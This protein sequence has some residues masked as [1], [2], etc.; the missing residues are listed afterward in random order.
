MRRRVLKLPPEAAGGAKF[1]LAVC[2]PGVEASRAAQDGASLLLRFGSEAEVICM[3]LLCCLPPL[4]CAHH[5]AR[6]A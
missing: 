5:A 4:S 3:P 2:P 6:A 1:V